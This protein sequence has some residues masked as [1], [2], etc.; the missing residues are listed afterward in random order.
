MQWVFEDLTKYI[1]FA[2]KYNT[3]TMKNFKKLLFTNQPCEAW[4]LTL[5]S[6]H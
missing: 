1:K 5:M 3:K 6:Q 2:I 4:F